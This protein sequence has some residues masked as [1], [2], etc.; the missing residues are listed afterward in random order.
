LTKPKPQNKTIKPRLTINK[1]NTARFVYNNTP[2][3]RIEARRYLA[4]M[5]ASIEEK[6]ANAPIKKAE[7]LRHIARLY[8]ELSAIENQILSRDYECILRENISW[9]LEILDKSET[10]DTDH[11]A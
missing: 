7:I 11:G 3:G 8:D 1:E 5:L 2:G 9:A 4:R 6:K 10:E